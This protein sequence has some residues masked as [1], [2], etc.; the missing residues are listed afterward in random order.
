MNESL[1]T[2]DGRSV[3][4]M[5]RR[6][7]HPPQK[8]W[9]AITEPEHLR[10]W[11]PAAMET[12]LRVGADIAFDFGDR[13][14]PAPGGVITELDPPR[15]F[16]FTWGDDLLH[17]EILP[18]GAGS[19]LVLTYTFSDHYG[20]AS[21][22]SGWETCIDA[23][24][25]VLDGRPVDAPRPSAERHDAY[26]M[27]FGLDEGV[28]EETPGG[29]QV[30]FERQLTRP[31][32]A[33]WAA[34]TAGATVTPGDPAP[35]AVTAAEIPAGAVTSSDPP[36]LIEYAWLA[37]GEP[38]GLVRWELKEGTGH[39]A[40][41]VLTQTGPRERADERATALAAW[42]THLQRLAKHLAAT[43]G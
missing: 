8:V 30:R 37:G 21:F 1:R 7:K 5:E 38:A 10:Q 3:L 19:V 36:N 35:P 20:A 17:W 41:L 14:T 24:E 23:L 6:L 16:A 13:A 2:I 15:V 22:A 28:A 27:E 26:V 11:F 31:V 9:R 34:L 42:K 39:G 40:R 18:D 25:Q 33:V 32:D 29:W 4:R 43:A 12:E